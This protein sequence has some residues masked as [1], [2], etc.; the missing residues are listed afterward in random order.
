VNLFVLHYHFRPGGIRRVIELGTPAI[1]RALHPQITRVVLCSGEE[2]SPAWLKPFRARLGKVP[3]EVV[4]EG[5][6]GYYSEIA[7]RFPDVP[8]SVRKAVHSLAEKMKREP[9]AVWAHNLGLGRNIFLSREIAKTCEALRLPLIAH[10]HDWWFDNRWQRWPEFRAGGFHQLR[11]VAR[12]IFAAG[13]RVRHVAI[14]HADVNI[15]RRHIGRKAAWLPNPV[16]DNPLPDERATERARKWLRKAT[17]G[18]HREF[19]IVPCRL[20][21]RKNVAESLL[22][23][24]WLRPEACLVT[25]GGPSSS[26]E[27]SCAKRLEGAAAEHRWPLRLGVLADAPAAAPRVAELLAASE[28][29]ILTSIQEGFGLPFLEAASA[30]RPMV[31]RR[32]DN[33][34]P[35]LESLGLRLPQCYGEILVDP[36]LF[37]LKA[38]LA[39]QRHL[40]S[41]WKKMLPETVLR[42][43]KTPPFLKPRAPE[44]PVPF[45]R[46]TLSAQIEVLARPLEESWE[47]GVAL[48]PWLADWRSLAAKGGLRLGSGFSRVRRSLST[49]AYGRHFKEI[50]KGADGPPSEAAASVAAQREFIRERLGA[51][52]L[53]PLLWACES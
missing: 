27:L 45:S 9:C 26:E 15:L 21:R 23:T 3:V 53:Y 39:R 18:A 11:E 44:K 29:V 37:D 12:E 49:R 1:V 4:V 2:I 43:V 48:N 19:W 50:L 33:V 24:R 32:L 40:F 20:L 51:H 28:V 14:N 16:Q 38:E 46:L 41:A 47:R 52:N 5:A 7:G 10:H 42:F 8:E 36:A 34:L 25:T 17:G 31:A 6:L 22:L 35:D 30:R 13:G